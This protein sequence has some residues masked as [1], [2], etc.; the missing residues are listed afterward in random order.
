MSAALERLYAILGALADRQGAPAFAE[1]DGRM[2][3][4]QRGVYFVFE[5]GEVRSASSEVSRVVRVG[6]HALNA[7]SGTTLWKRLRQH[8]GTRAGS[9]NHRGSVFR[10]H[11]G[12]ALIAREGLQGTYP[13]WDRGGNASRDVVRS[14]RGMEAMASEVI[15]R[16]RV[17]WVAVPDDPGP[18]SDRGFIERCAIALLASDGRAVDPPSVTWLGRYAP[19]AAIRES[20]L[21]NVNHVGSETV[22]GFLD[23]FAVYAEET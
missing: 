12:R 8:R 15:G 3:W 13:E 21:W 14:E 5:P 9:G 11:V 22:T 17:A 16:M 1:L 4:P 10:M 2:P 6:T 7:G 23:A 19:S 18:R 20:G